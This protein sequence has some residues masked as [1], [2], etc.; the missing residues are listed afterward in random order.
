MVLAA[1][2]PDVETGCSKAASLRP[3]PRPRSPHAALH[4]PSLTQP[5]PPPTHPQR[6]T[7][8]QRPRVMVSLAACALFAF[9][10][11]PAL[12]YFTGVAGLVKYW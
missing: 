6:Y 8:K 12:T 5:T 1:A 7:E 3:Q 11:L 9:G 10:A 4:P 2:A